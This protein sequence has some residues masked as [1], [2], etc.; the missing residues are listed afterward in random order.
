MG[1]PAVQREKNVR[2]RGGSPAPLCPSGRSV[3]SQGDRPEVLLRS[4]ESSDPPWT[5][6]RVVSLG[7]WVLVG[8]VVVATAFGLWRAAR[9]G[10]FRG[11][12]V[13]KDATPDA[14]PVE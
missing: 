6:W 5:F 10:R 4:R 13:V 1:S 11:T 2:C 8:A 14:A 12:H 7:V 9:D 3:T